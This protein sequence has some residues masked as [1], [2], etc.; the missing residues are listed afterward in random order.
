MAMTG[1]C[2]TPPHHRTEAQSRSYPTS[3][4]EQTTAHSE[5][6]LPVPGLKPSPEVCGHMSADDPRRQRLPQ[7]SARTGFERTGGNVRKRRGHN[8]RLYA[9]L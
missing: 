7:K 6:N 3:R 9:S 5:Y 2:E 8:R 1:M 4:I